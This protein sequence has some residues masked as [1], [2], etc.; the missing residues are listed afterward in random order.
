MENKGTILYAD[1]E[2][3]IRNLMK[4]ILG[5]EF[6]NHHIE[7]FEDG[8]SLERRLTNGIENV[9]LV[10]TD[11]QMPGITGREIIRKYAKQSGFEQIPFVL[12]Y[13]GDGS[14]G[15]SLVDEGYASAYLRK[16]VGLS[17]L[18]NTLKNVLE[19]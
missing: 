13:A 15:R 4:I 6:P 2:P 11:N 9:R 18:K 10:L 16:P 8:S 7:V 5:S 14:I 3:S 17:D 19:N 1:D 12:C